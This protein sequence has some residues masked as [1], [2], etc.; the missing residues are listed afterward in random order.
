M[1]GPRD[2]GRGTGNRGRSC[3]FA[4]VHSNARRRKGEPAADLPIAAW[5]V[6]VLGSLMW[7]DNTAEEGTQS[8]EVYRLQDPTVHA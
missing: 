8:L 5:V 6:D 7:V 3:I 4:H 2:E 1:G